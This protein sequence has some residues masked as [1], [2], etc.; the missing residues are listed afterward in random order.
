MMLKMKFGVAN[1]LRL[2]LALL[3]LEQME[4]NTMIGLEVETLVSEIF[5]SL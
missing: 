2:H 5:L 3:I 1:G 4:Q